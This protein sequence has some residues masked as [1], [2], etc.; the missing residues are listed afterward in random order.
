[1]KRNW[2]STGI[3]PVSGRCNVN[4]LHFNCLLAQE[5]LS[6]TGRLAVLMIE[7]LK[8]RDEWWP[9]EKLAVQIVDAQSALSVA[10]LACVM[11]STMCLDCT[12]RIGELK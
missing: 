1:M 12:R 9:D 11:H 3:A 8:A 10:T 5:Q 6:R 7:T 2:I 4:E